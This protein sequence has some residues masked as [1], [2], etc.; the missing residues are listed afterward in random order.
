MTERGTGEGLR[1]KHARPSHD[2]K[3]DDEDGSEFDGHAKSI[4]PFLLV[5]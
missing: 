4:S 2:L 3:D 1:D 5:K